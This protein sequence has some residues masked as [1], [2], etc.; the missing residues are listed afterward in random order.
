MTRH[1][2][3]VD[4]HRVAVFEAGSGPETIMLVHG[5]PD[6]SAVYRGQIPGLLEAGYRMI[7]PD[8]LGHGD[9]DIPHGVE[10]YTIAKDEESHWAVGRVGG[11]GLPPRRARS[12]RAVDLVDGRASAGPGAVRVA[13]SIGHPGAL[14][15][16]GYEQRSSR[17]ANPGRR[18]L[19]Y[20][21]VGATTGTTADEAA[22]PDDPPQ[23]ARRPRRRRRSVPPFLAGGTGHSGMIQAYT[24]R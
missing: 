24:P 19:P 21:L 8:L 12:R 15:A 3:F 11:R 13:M 10:N 23:V 7:V 18:C 14:K 6:S 5:I 16:A 17:A 9:S 20:T 4:G 2:V 1:S 22:E